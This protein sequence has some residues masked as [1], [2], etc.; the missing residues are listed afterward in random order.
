MGEFLDTIGEIEGEES[1]SG[2]QLD[3]NTL[4]SYTIDKG[5]AD[6]L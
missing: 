2:R 3:I 1:G 6:T 5:A 4:F